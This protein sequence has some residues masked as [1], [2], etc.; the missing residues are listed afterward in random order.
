MGRGEQDGGLDL[1]GQVGGRRRVDD[2]CLHLH[3]RLAGRVVV[4]QPA[5]GDLDR[6][7][8]VLDGDP[9]VR[10]DVAQPDDD[11]QIADELGGG[12]GEQRKA[13]RQRHDHERVA[14]AVVVERRVLGRIEGVQRDEL[15]RRSRDDLAEW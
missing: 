2:P 8:V 15:V 6:G 3:A 9:A 4:R 11:E 5:G 1:G 10:A 13:Q 7:R 12:L 14:E